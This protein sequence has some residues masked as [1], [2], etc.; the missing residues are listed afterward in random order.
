LV[1]QILW[2]KM[3]CNKKTFWTT[4]AFFILK[5]IF[6]Y[7]LWEGETFCYAFLSLI[8]LPFE[9]VHFTRIVTNLV[10]KTEHKYRLPMLRN[11]HFA[12]TSFDLWMSTGNSTWHFCSCH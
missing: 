2:K 6:C 10:E 3:I 9:K 8:C 4:L 11:F 12:I 1:Q 7:N 5:I